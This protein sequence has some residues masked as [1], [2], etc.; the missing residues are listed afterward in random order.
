MR[1]LTKVR[2]EGCEVPFRRLQSA[3]ST[4][5]KCRFDACESTFCLADSKE[6]ENEHSP[7]DQ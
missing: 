3:V 2:F 4:L 7:L 6:L 5:A 1:L